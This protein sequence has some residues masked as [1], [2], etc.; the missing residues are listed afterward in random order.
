MKKKTELKITGMTCAGCSSS[1][2]RKL[3]SLNGIES[4]FV[5]L[6]LA[7]ASVEFDDSVIDEKKIIKAVSSLGFG[8]KPA[9]ESDFDEDEKQ[10]ERDYFTLKL[11][12]IIAVIFT[13]PLFYI[14]MFPMLWK[15]TPLPEFL[16]MEV[17]ALNYALTQ[18]VLAVPVIIVGHRFFTRGFFN[19][20]KGHPNMDSLIAV[21]TSAAFIYSV[22]N[23]ISIIHDSHHSAHNLYY[24]S[25]AVIITLV[26]LGKT[27]EASSK[28][29]TG[30]A[31]KALIKLAPK[32]AVIVKDGEEIE[33]LI[34]EVKPEDTVVVRPGEKI[35][36][37]GVVIE[38]S[39][40]VDESMLTGESMPVDKRTGD[41]VT[42]GSINKNGYIRFRATKVGKDTTL[43]QIIKLVEETQG[44]KAPVAKLADVVSGRFVPVVI[45]IAVLSGLGW[46]VAGAGLAFSM[47]IFISVLVI[48]CPCALG[49]ATPIGIMVG[50][51]KGA[52]NGVLFK[53]G[54]ALEI[55]HTVKTVVFDKT[56]TITEGKPVVTDVIPFGGHEAD[57]LLAYAASAESGSEH[58]L[59]QAVI[60]H[61]KSEKI[62]V[63]KMSGFEAISGRGLCA[64]V[65][66]KKVLFGNL[67]LMNDGSVDV[68]DY[69]KQGEALSSQGKTPMYLS[70]GGEFFGIIAVADVIK[71]TSREAVSKLHDLG[72]KTVMITGDNKKT[73]EYIAKQAGID[74]VI[75][76]VMP[77]DKADEILKLKTGKNRV[78]MVGDGINDAPALVTADVGIA[79][80]NG[81]DVAIESADVV[82]MRSDL[83]GVSFGISLS[84]ATLKNIKQ[85]LF[86]A[87]GYNVL[88]IPVAAGLLHIF[89][90]PVLN[91]MIAAAAMSLSS[92]SVV[93]NSL[94]LN[95]FKG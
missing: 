15:D 21:G 84:R 41:T 22:I 81:T 36:V 39:T 5:N 89:G 26:L 32:T 43:S 12:L 60:A 2:E 87:M 35:P 94:R 11:K 1:I 27:L 29:K 74:A 40:S 59:G 50:T 16:N 49:L 42:G 17:H 6:P 47:K 76:E 67:K 24:E 95:S 33:V 13:S 46:L 62:P 3:G 14:A 48:A 45:A 91:P 57:E 10:R 8:A 78:A 69:S 86:W 51:G 64:D 61:A 25:T 83:K 88:G 53:S 30:S 4:A 20:F 65:L 34:D 68:F 72:I 37:D 56:G 58:P 31:I 79:V 28:N 7:T 82:L 70:V 9:S 80:G 92:V 75:S 54:E 44:T 77:A 18:L 55:L 66:G 71:E 85:N 38:G 90:G 63:L 23:T 73:A 93:T 52:Q 19:L